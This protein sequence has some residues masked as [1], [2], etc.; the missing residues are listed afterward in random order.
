MDVSSDAEI[1]LG[2]GDIVEM[3][4]AATARHKTHSSGLAAVV[5]SPISKLIS[6]CVCETQIG[7]K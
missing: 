5:G 2:D 4:E 6:H 7:I 1:L 3:D